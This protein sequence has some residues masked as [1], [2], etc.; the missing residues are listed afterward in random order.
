MVAGL[1]HHHLGQQRRLR[2]AASHR[3]A[4]L[5]RLEL[6]QAAYAGPLRAHMEHDLEAHQHVLQLRRD[7]AAD[8]VQLAAALAAVAGPA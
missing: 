6:P 5:S 4:G 8:F 3:A 1:G 7:G 2:K